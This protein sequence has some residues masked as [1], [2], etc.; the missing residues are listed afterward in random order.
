MKEI[1]IYSKNYPI[2]RG[3]FSEMFRILEYSFPKTERRDMNAH[4]SEFERP[5]FRSMIVEDGTVIGFMNYWE[6]T[7]FVYLEHFAVAKEFR[8]HGLGAELM[9][10]LRARTSNRPIILEAEPPEQ[11]DIALRRVCFYERIGFSLNP[12][13][14]LQPPYHDGEAPLPLVLMSAPH[15]L[16]YE[17][18][19]KIRNTLYREAYELPQNSDLYSVK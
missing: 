8:G 15:P 1:T 11:G 7:G 2:P 3:I 10:E 19:I 9:S 12:Y 18:F 6:L 5:A 4:F 17:E 13:S 16:E 14:Y